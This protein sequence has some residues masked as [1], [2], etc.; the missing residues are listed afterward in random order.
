MQFFDTHCHIY[1][2]EY[3]LPIA[4]VEKQAA[5]AGV[6]Y[7]LCVGVDVKTSRQA[8]AFVADRP[9]AWASVGLHPHDAGLG[10]E[11]FGEL[12][13][14]LAEEDSASQGPLP[15][16]AASGGPVEPQAVA[17]P[18]PPFGSG[19]PPEAAWPGRSGAGPKI[20][21][22]GECGLDYFYQNSPKEAQEKALRFQIELALEHDLPMIFHVREAFDDFWPI[23][24]SYKNIRGVLHSF[25]DS[26][27]NMQKA[28]ERNLYIG[29]NGIMTFTKNQWQLDVAK[30]V[31]LQNLLLETDAPFLTPRPFRGSVNVPA[32]TRV[33]AEFLATLRGESLERLARATTRNAHN[34]FKTK[35]VTQP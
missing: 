15:G 17:R 5:A 30:S 22:I 19:K 6:N 27:A 10:E 2:P 29:L 3:P 11:E 23:F 24:D 34:L 32:Y 14:I 20:V 35:I 33:V 8:V 13:Q 4:D 18:V 26:Q 9:N 28:L 7:L 16:Q 12:R 31:P 21:A 25:T 1:E